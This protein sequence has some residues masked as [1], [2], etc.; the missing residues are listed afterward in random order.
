[1]G[2]AGAGRRAVIARLIAPLVACGMFVSGCGA[3]PFSYVKNSKDQLYFKV[4][5][6]WHKLDA[7]SVD[8]VAAAAGQAL[9]TQGTVSWAAAFDGSKNPSADHIFT[10]S[11]AD[12]VILA[13]VL[14]MTSTGQQTLSFDA[15]RDLLL[16]VTD[17]ARAKLPS[18]TPLSGFKS[19]N[20]EVLTKAHGLHG[21]HV[22]YAYSLNNG[23][24][25]AFDQTVLTNGD[26]TKLY[27][28]FARCSADCYLSQRS[29][30]RS[31]V[32]SFTVGG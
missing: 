15:M 26:S 18:D 29:K 25:Q 23:P 19:L 31:V 9:A 28:L 11:T 14:D 20:D 32:N 17:A 2:L 10:A 3:A 22:I 16:P 27:L 13:E 30:I 12:P 7:K 4:P 6:G 24:I 5:S 1:M 8:A 21:V